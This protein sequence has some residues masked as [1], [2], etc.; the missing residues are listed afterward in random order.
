MYEV[1]GNKRVVMGEE[2]STYQRK[3][4]NCNILEVEAGTSGYRSGDSGH[5]GRTY[6]RIS[7]LGGTDINARAKTDRWGKTG[8]IEVE[9]GGDAE[10]D[11]II[12]A[13]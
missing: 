10:L 4:T 6:F 3:I 9:L 7:D 2:I 1:T 13:L 5:G 12:Q 11:T 8:S